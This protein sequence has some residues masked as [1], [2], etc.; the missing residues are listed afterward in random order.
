MRAHGWVGQAQSPFGGA[1]RLR[2]KGKKS[3]VWGEMKR[4]LR[5][6]RSEAMAAGGVLRAG[7]KGG[8][9]LFAPPESKT[10]EIFLGKILKNFL[11]K[12]F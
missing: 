11:E 3:A 8:W 5:Q 4:P 10:L 6:S 7:R 9:G 12:R 1:F 2:A